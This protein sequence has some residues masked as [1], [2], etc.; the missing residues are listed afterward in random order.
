M[1]QQDDDE[2]MGMGG[3]RKGFMDMVILQCWVV[4]ERSPV[5]A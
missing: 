4:D 1:G 2:G 3:R 5:W